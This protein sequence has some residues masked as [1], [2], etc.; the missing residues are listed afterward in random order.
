MAGQYYPIRIMY[1][2]K[3][4]STG[5]I[6][7]SW[8]LPGS[9]TVITNGTSYFAQGMYSTNNTINGWLLCDGA[10]YNV[11]SYPSL[12]ISIGKK[13]GGDGITTFRVPN[14]MN[15]MVRGA[16]AA[17][18]NL[19][20]AEGSNLFLLDRNY[21]SA[22][23]HSANISSDSWSHTHTLAARG[24]T[25]PDLA[26]DNQFAEF[27]DW[28]VDPWGGDLYSNTDFAGLNSGGGHTH[29]Y[30]IGSIGGS[31]PINM[32]PKSIYVNYIIKT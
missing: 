5:S 14:L 28:G 9:S 18:T 11:S 12:A 25:M 32:K 3:V 29:D 31:A 6:S 23:S 16:H 21:L 15:T 26:N 4:N 2:N 7:F 27:G 24:R 30:N 19:P 20:I 17:N 8:K 13:Y 22:H 10:K 1:G